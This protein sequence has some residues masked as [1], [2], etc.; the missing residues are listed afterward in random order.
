MAGALIATRAALDEEDRLRAVLAD[1]HAPLPEPFTEDL[2]VRLAEVALDPSSG[3]MDLAVLL[4]QVL[5]RW[6]LR[7]NRVERVVVAGSLSERLRPVAA[8]TW[9]REQA[10]DVWHAMPWQP[11]WLDGNGV[12]DV[13]ANTGPI[14]KP[15]FTSVDLPADP[16]FTR[17]TGH[18]SYRTPGQRAAC[19][20][21]VSAPSGSAL[22]AMLPTGSGKTEIALC[23]AERHDN[24]V[25]LIVVPT[26]ALAYDFERRFRD[27]YARLRPRANKTALTFAW[28]SE[29]PEGERERLRT[30]VREGR[31]PLLVTSPESVSRVLRS[32]LMDAAAS[33][34]LGGIVVDEAHLV[35]Q[36]GRDFRPEFRTLGHLRA[37][38]LDAARPSGRLPVTLMLSAT[39]GA[40]ELEDLHEL[41]GKPGPTTLVAANALRPEPDIWIADA[42]DPEE[43][44]ARVLET[45][46][47][48]PRPAIL[49]VTRPESARTWVE[50]LRARGY[51]RV[52]EV[53]GK[54]RVDNRAQVLAALRGGEG[55]PT[56]TDLVV[57]TSAFGLGIDY[58]HLRTVIHACLPETVDRWYQELGRAGR[59]GQA[60]GAFLLTA[61]AADLPEAESLTTKVLTAEN[62]QQRWNDLWSHRKTLRGLDFLDLEGNRGTVGEGSYNRRWNAQLVQGLVEL[63]ALKRYRVDFD[64]VLALEEESGR[65]P[66]WAAVEVRRPIGGHKAF[67][68][69]TWSDWQKAQWTR[70]RHALVAMR[71]VAM[72]ESP[73]CTAIASYYQAGSNGRDL[74]GVA[75]CFVEPESKCGRCPGCRRRGV[76]PPHDPPPRPPQRWPVR[77]ES[78]PQLS[79]LVETVGVGSDLVVLWTDD[80]PRVAPALA[81][82]LVSR[83]IN[84]LA[85]SV[86][87]IPQEPSW[88]LVDPEPVHPADLTPF[89]SFVVYERD[90]RIPGAWLNSSVRRAN[91]PHEFSAVDV[92]LVGPNVSIDGRDVIRELRAVNARTAL[93]ILGA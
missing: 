32:T 74:F 89:S 8:E 73:A 64:D 77:F 38:L 34:R 50:R 23:L 78:A 90:T 65:V 52:S 48:T 46:A 86:G 61:Q 21:V 56:R 40:H 54:T 63:N 69:E 88:L 87:V 43:R 58:P 42:D 62:A 36:W 25:C 82:A 35:T 4:R 3:R 44:D 57:A 31:Q 59:D 91:R 68:T 47:N 37:E 29:T 9:L 2:N 70:S 81:R 24:A 55:S 49:Y 28:T 85:G 1:P 19:R 92:L 83:G 45:L 51:H 75:A 76:K 18:R 11:A 33:G 12:P 80:H 10:G 26:I 67:W 60:S 20:A 41:F 27:H 17:V 13:A 15:R 6:S 72:D 5:R 53:T 14:V 71:G 39:L 22:I 16:F 66:D 84:H 93:Q 30:A 79:E 7:N